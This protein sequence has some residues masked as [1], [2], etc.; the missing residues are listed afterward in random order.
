MR[1]FLMP[2]KSCNDL[3]WRWMLISLLWNGK[4][5][6]KS[7]SFSSAF[8]QF[9]TTNVLVPLLWVKTARYA[10]DKKSNYIFIR[11]RLWNR[12]LILKPVSNLQSGR[13]CAYQSRCVCGSNS[14]MRHYINLYQYC[15]SWYLMG[16]DPV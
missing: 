13:L 7:S 11:K 6:V 16:I 9:V 10:S 12:L 8:I 1:L 5:N 3:Q 4:W 2:L 15:H 14:F